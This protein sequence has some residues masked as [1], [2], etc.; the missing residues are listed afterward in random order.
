M[1]SILKALEDGKIL[2][3]DGG[4]GT[5][6]HELGLKAG[7]CPEEWNVTHREEVLGI[8]KSY[9][10]AGSDMILTNTFGG[11][12]IRLE[13]YGFQDRASEFNEAGTKISREAAGDDH[14]VLG[15]I[16]PSSAILMMGDV[17]EEKVFDGFRIQAE[18][19]A[20]AGADAICVET[21]SEIAEAVLAVKAAKEFTDLEVLCTFTYQKTVQ[22]YFR[23]MMGVSPEEMVAAVLDAG[24]DIIGAN[25]G[26]GFEQMIDIV[27]IIREI[28]KTT[29]VLIH[30]N[31]GMPEV[32]DNKTI[33]P[34]TPDI[35]RS[36][37]NDLIDA[38]ANIIGGCCGTTPDHIRAFVRELRG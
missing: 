38:G 11:H 27:K 26:M 16:G 9:I 4:W 28:N 21:M 22:G 7:E 35:M 1:R 29:P 36:R 18:A 23:T 10:E 17:P 33:F 32:K 30:A 3:S 8:A 5:F 25:C 14:F 12:P 15:S 37:V 20:K 13:H 24:A 2:I 19:M 31:A 6:L 34:E